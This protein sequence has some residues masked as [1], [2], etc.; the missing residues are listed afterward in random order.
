MAASRW[1]FQIKP[2][3]R[4]VVARGFRMDAVGEAVEREVNEALPYP[5]KFHKVNKIVI[6]LGPAPAD[7]K[8]YVELLGIGLKQWPEFNLQ[9]Y[10]SLSEA[11]KTWALKRAVT[12][13]FEWLVETFPDA[14]FAETAKRHLIWAA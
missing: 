11:E 5:F 7:E 14:Q 1:K 4:D 12:Q 13:T 9:H 8:D 6:C 10:L 2:N 3:Q